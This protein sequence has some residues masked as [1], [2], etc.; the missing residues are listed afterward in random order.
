MFSKILI[1]NR[2][3]IAV[4]II[5]ACNE[6]GIKTVAIYSDEDKDSLHVQIADEAV[7]IGKAESN[8]SIKLQTEGI[9]TPKVAAYG[10]CWGFIFEKASF[11]I[12][13]E[14]R[15]AESLERKLPDCFSS[16]Y[17]TENLRDRKAFIK[18]LAAFIRKLHLSGYCHRDLYLCHTFDDGGNFSLIDLTRVFK[19]I[20]FSNRYKIKDIAQLYYSAPGSTFSR[21]DRLRF[22][23]EYSGH[24]KLTNKD[25]KFISKVKTKAVRMAQHDLRHGRAVPFR[26]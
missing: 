23:I 2:G 13:E 6:M 22:Y 20:L 7:C 18:K 5:R 4:R 26:N 8:N 1:A 17:K 24:K 12:T 3:E 16:Q 9:N 15:N 21:T 14:I 11:L 25:K 19:P 10:E